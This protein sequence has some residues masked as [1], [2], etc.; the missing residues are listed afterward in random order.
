MANQKARCGPGA[1]IAIRSRLQEEEQHE[2]GLSA[3]EARYAARRAFGN[4]TLIREHTR[5]VWGWM[6]LERFLQDIHYALRGFRRN[7]VFTIAVIA[8]L[9]VGIGATTAVFSVVD[10]I[11]F[12]AFPMPR[13]IAWFPSEWCILSERQEFMMGMFFFDWRDNQKPFEA[14]A[15]QSTMP[16]A[17]DLVENNPAQLSCLSFDAGL[18]PLLGVSPVVGR[19]FLPEEDRP[20]APDVVLISYGLWQ[21]HYNRDPGI[22]AGPSTW[23]ASRLAL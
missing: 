16:H 15:I 23:T 19:N 4:P 17:C 7:P 14:M 21:D 5:E 13:T 3:E 22:R 8:T 9:A 6:R 10:R 11:L 2:S 18:L 12:A 20:K 1:R